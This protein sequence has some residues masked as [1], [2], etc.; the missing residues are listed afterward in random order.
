MYITTIEIFVF[1]FSLD[2]PIPIPVAPCNPEE[3][4]REPTPSTSRPLLRGA[5]PGQTRTLSHNENQL[6]TTKDM[7]TQPIVVNATSSSGRPVPNFSSASTKGAIDRVNKDDVNLGA[8]CSTTHPCPPPSHDPDSS[9]HSSRVSSLDVG[10]VNISCLRSLQSLYLDKVPLQCIK[11]LP[12]HSTLN[13][14]CL[15]IRRAGITSLS[16]IV[17]QCGADQVSV[18]PVSLDCLS[19]F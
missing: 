10:H 11:G 14:Q 12:C 17:V 6:P 19:F 4:M 13:L 3:Q 7:S 8:S 5:N 18:K 2:R 9:C 15:T 1:V 16:E